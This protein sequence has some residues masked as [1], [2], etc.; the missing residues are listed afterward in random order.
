MF[1][2]DTQIAA[3]TTDSYTQLE[4]KVDIPV[5]M[6]E[7]FSVRSAQSLEQQNV[8][9]DWGDN[10]VTVLKDQVSVETQDLIATTD[11]GVY[12]SVE[13]DR[14]YEHFCWH[15]YAAPGKYIVKVY[16][17]TYWG[18]RN[19]SHSQYNLISRLFDHDLP[20]AKCCVNISHIGYHALRLQK[21]SPQPYF[22]MTFIENM[23]FAFDGCTNLL[24]VK[25][26]EKLP[27]MCNPVAVNNV[28]ANCTNLTT[29]D[30]RLHPSATRYKNNWESFYK[31]CSN[32]AVDVLNLLPANGFSGKYVSAPEIFQN[33]AKLTCSDYNKLANILWNDGHII[34]SNPARVFTGCSSLNLAKI[35]KS[36]GGTM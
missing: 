2:N 13:D 10:T 1:P 18:L 7:M 30:M 31:N 8:I 33:C 3:G 32:L 4:Y 16:G 22:N 24:E 15:K 20:L 19:K 28:F 17:N 36:W 35:P 29:S 21:L 9:I 11:D 6:T 26:F 14:E 12:Q 5:Q 23:A 25:N 27:S 34:W